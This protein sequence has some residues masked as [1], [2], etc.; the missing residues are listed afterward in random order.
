MKVK[1]F[2]SAEEFS[3][4]DCIIANTD[5]NLI[6]PIKHDIKWNDENKIFR[7]SIWS[8]DGELVSA[9]WKKFTNLGEQLEFEPIDIDS[10]I[11][12]IH[13]LDGSTLIISKFKGELIVRTRGTSDATILDNGDEIVFLKQ[14]YPLVFNNDYLNTEQHSIVCEWYSPRNIIVEREA[15]EPTLWLT[16]VIK[17]DDY[18]YVLQNDLDI[19]AT[20][21]KVERPIRY[22]FNSISSMIES[23]NQWKKGEGIVIYGNN[24][25]ILKK[26]KSDRYLLLHRI[27]SQLSSTKN[28]I[29]FYIEKEMPSYEEFYK[30]IETEFDF[31]IAVQLKEE[32][33]KICEAGEKAKKYIDHILEV[34][35]DIRKVE[36]RKEQALMIKR[37]FKENSSFVF[38]VLDGKIITK[39]QWT[40]LINQN[41]ES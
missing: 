21:W 10:D 32:L 19:F 5:C 28:L 33:E 37:N 30:I 4:R 25:Q 7:S 9:S 31:E 39:E 22:Q 36:T 27:K 38:S 26:T 2:P 35:H 20:D 29:D 1:N 15:E 23:V 13:K 12:F 8:K 40:K 6:F 24:G 14:K 41:Y 11:E 17:H 34:V 3:I 18:S 16:G